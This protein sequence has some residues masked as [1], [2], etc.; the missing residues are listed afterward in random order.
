MSVYTKTT[1]FA[2]KDS[3]ITGDPDKV[4]RGSEID[5]EFEN[6]E[7]AI[8]TQDG[9]LTYL[10]SVSGTNTITAATAVAMTAYATGQRFT[11]IPANVNT[12]AV[13]INVNSIGAKAITKDGTTALVGGELVAGAAYFIVYDGTRFILAGHAPKVFDV[14][15]FGATGASDD[16]TAIQAALDAAGAGNA[17]TTVLVPKGLACLISGPLDMPAG[18]EL[19]LHG[20]IQVTT[21][22]ASDTMGDGATSSAMVYIGQTAHGAAVNGNYDNVWHLNCRDSGN[23]ARAAHA[24]E[25]YGNAN[26]GNRVENILCAYATSSNIYVRGTTLFTHFRNVY[27][28]WSPRGYDLHYSDGSG[29]SGPT[30][31]DGCYAVQ[32]GT[33]AYV[34]NSHVSG[35]NLACDQCGNALTTYGNAHVTLQGFTVEGSGT[36]I[37]ASSDSWIS[38]DGGL[39]KEPG[40]S[41]GYTSSSYSGNGSVPGVTTGIYLMIIDDSVLSIKNVQFETDFTDVQRIFNGG[42]NSLVKLS[43]LSRTGPSASRDSLYLTYLS[44]FSVSSTCKLVDND[45]DED[46]EYTATITCGTSGTVTLDASYNTLAYTQKGRM[47]TVTGN[48]AVTSVSSPTGYFAINLPKAFASLTENADRAA[49]RVIVTGTNAAKVSDFVG[50]I[51]GSEIDVY[52]GDATSLQTDSAQELKANSNIYIEATYFTTAA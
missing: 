51:V 38:I 15:A 37:D 27:S 14:R 45:S 9:T 23:T 32:C 16:R 13:T 31:I 1:D 24:V 8:S 5:A 6:I 44:Q 40:T 25:I 35:I 50:V 42:A 26:K 34:R 36:W 20:T 47:I 29:A 12:G 18:T 10:T 7:T 21:G 4:I 39:V 41:A 52:L 49:A 46:G 22:F 3:L 28:A 48:L 17:M 11:F 43:N 2:S 33:G 19:L 30:T